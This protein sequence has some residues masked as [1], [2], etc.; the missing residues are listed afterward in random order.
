MCAITL[1]SVCPTSSGSTRNAASTATARSDDLE[2][3]LAWHRAVTALPRGSGTPGGRRHARRQARP[4]LGAAAWRAPSPGSLAPGHGLLTRGGEHERLAQRRALEALGQ[5]QRAQPRPGAVVEAV[6]VD[7]EHLERLALVPGRAGQHAG[8]ARHRP[9]PRRRGCAGAARRRSAPVP[10]EPR[11]EQVARRRRSPAASRRRSGRRRESQ[12]KK[13]KPSSRARRRARAATRATAPRRGD[14][15]RRSA[16]RRRSGGRRR[17]APAGGSTLVTGAGAA[18][19]GIPARAG[20]VPGRG[21]R[22]R[23]SPA[24][25]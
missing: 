20:A 23:S 24:A 10:V 13:S 21:P 4:A 6:E 9:R 14:G 19:A 18:R 16:L 5:Q 15:R 11:V 22:R 8:Q 17:A 2:P 25:G 12:S 3:R 1:C 7:A